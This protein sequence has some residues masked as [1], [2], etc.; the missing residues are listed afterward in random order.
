MVV[1]VECFYGEELG[2]F[3]NVVVGV[4]VVWVCEDVGDVGVVVIV[5]V[6]GNVFV[7]GIYCCVDGCLVSV[8]LMMWGD[9]GIDDGNVDVLFWNVVVI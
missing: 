8:E 5:I 7:N 6:S 3:G 4:V 1:G 2:V 9:V